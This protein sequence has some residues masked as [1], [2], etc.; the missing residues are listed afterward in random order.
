MYTYA[1]SLI[2]VAKSDPK[3]RKGKEEEEE[4]KKEEKEIIFGVDKWDNKSR[5]EKMRVEIEVIRPFFLGPDRPRRYLR[6]REREKSERETRSRQAG[7]QPEWLILLQG[8]IE[9]SNEKKERKKWR[10]Y[11][12]GWQLV[13][14]IDRASQGGKSSWWGSRPTNWSR[15]IQHATDQV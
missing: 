10:W 14:E 4:R 3:K 2:S 11:R 7:R 1:P 12:T 13:P 15:P 9:I 6:E 5:V 8:S